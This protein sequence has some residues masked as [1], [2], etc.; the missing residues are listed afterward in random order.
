MAVNLMEAFKASLRL[1]GLTL[2]C[3]LLLMVTC[4]LSLATCIVNVAVYMTEKMFGVQ[5]K[6]S[7]E[8]HNQ[9]QN[10]INNVRYEA[11][12]SGIIDSKT[13][14]S[15][16]KKIKFSPGTLIAKTHQLLTSAA[17]IGSKQ[18]D[19]L[20]DDFQATFPFA[21]PLD[22][23]TFCK[24]IR[25][26]NFKE[27]FPTANDSQLN[28]FGFTVD[29]TE[30]NRVWYFARPELVHRGDW[31][32]GLLEIRKTYSTVS[33]TAQVFS[34]SFNDEGKCYKF[35]G[36]YPVDRTSGNCGGLGGLLGILHCIKPRGLPFTEGRPWSPSL[37]WQLWYDRVPQMV[38]ECRNIL[39]NLGLRR[40][41]TN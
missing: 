4:W 11:G 9:R 28:Y 38:E 30:L 41:G 12:D 39:T 7:L 1:I 13:T 22:K 8:F 23:P 6:S 29:P 40:S 37:E 32:F 10:N 25:S 21:G 33:G 36:G 34:M 19:L 5:V 15:S 31:S 26:L 20:A 16:A 3:F 35:T 18:P 14:F 27:A 2:S 17:E 24:T